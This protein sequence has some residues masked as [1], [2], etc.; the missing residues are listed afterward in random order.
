MFS[1]DR[2]GSRLSTCGSVYFRE[3]WEGGVCVFC[4][5]VAPEGVQVEGC[6]GEAWRP[7]GATSYFLGFCA[8]EDE[9]KG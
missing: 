6:S 4:L 1:F 3:N 9:K 2:R 8:L 7:Q 5:L